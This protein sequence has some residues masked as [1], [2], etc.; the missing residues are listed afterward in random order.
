MIRKYAEIFCWKNVSSFCSTKATHIFSAKNIRVLYIESAKTVNEMTL[1]ELVK[2]TTLWTTGP[3][4][5]LLSRPMILSQGK[6]LFRG[7]II[8]YEPEHNK[9]YKMAWA[10]SKD[11]DQ[12]GH[13]PSLIRV[14]TVCMKKALVLSYP[15]NAQRRLWSD[16]A[17]WSESSLGAHAILLVFSCADSYN[18]NLY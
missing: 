12:P 7:L 4:Y 16:W 15:L 11:P 5:P 3:W 2:L 6:F 17:I 18:L 14:F 9:T 8:L 1:D 13:P 10:P